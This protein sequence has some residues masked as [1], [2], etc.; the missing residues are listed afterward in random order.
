MTPETQNQ[1]KI[2]SVKILKGKD[3]DKPDDVHIGHEVH[4]PD[5]SVGKMPGGEFNRQPH[6][7][8]K[9]ALRKLRV[10]L[11]LLCDQIDI[12]QVNSEAVLNKFGVHG[13]IMTQGKHPGFMI[14]GDF[15]GKYGR[16]ALNNRNILLSSPI[17]E[18]HYPL[19]EML[20]KDMENVRR[21]AAAY[22]RGKSLA[23]YQSSM[24]ATNAQ[25]EKPVM[26][27][28]GPSVQSEL[29][30]K[31]P[32]E[33]LKATGSKIPAADPEAMERV[34]KEFDA[35]ETNA[36]SPEGVVAQ[37]VAESKFRGKIK[38]VPQS[39]DAKSGEIEE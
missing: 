16:V 22:L 5:G 6:P 2:L 23:D 39:P 1:L 26:L 9:E 31:E 24:F 27:P 28:E 12:K 3:D 18:E 20:F 7:E 11:A 4:Y 19:A 13:L 21:E 10:H 35:E 14:Y 17:L 34:K 29:Y 25:V 30:G 36:T 15:D 37:I 8:F 32:E 33:V 38:K